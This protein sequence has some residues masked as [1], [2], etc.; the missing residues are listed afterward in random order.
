MRKLKIDKAFL[1]TNLVNISPLEQEIICVNKRV[2]KSDKKIEK[3]ASDEI[4]T[5]F[6]K[7]TKK[8]RE[9]MREIFGPEDGKEVE[10]AF[11]L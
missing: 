6:Q 5:D 10:S 8:M 11:D 3:M 4:R 9:K 7:T 2:T 1:F